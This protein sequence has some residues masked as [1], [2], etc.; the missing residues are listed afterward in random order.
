[1]FKLSRF[2]KSSS[3]NVAMLFG[4]ALVPLMA[5]AG[6][7]IDMIR[8]SETRTILQNAADSAA[9]AGAS[10][11]NKSDDALALKVREFLTANNAREVMEYV[12]DVDQVLD[13][14]AGT[15]TVTVSGTIPGSV[16]SLF[17][18]KDLNVNA[19]SVANVGSGSLELAL[20][21]DNTGSMSGTKILNL[22][23]AAT[24]L[25]NII[26]AESSDNA[27]VKMAVVPFA[28]YVNVGMGNSGQ[29]WV[30][31]STTGGGP[32]EGC[33]G[34][35]PAPY[36]LNISA[37]GGD[38]PALSGVACN[39]PILPLTSNLDTV[40]AAI[41]AMNAEGW[42]YISGGLLWG[43]NVLDSA[44]PFTEGKSKAATATVRGQ[45]V[46][47]LMTDGENTRSYNYPNHSGTDV[48]LAN[49]ALEDTCVAAK[50]D[51]I[52][53]YTVSFMVLTPTV[54]NLLE[55]C[56]TTPSQYYDADNSAELTAAFKQIAQELAAVR[57][58]Q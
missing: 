2:L 49:T 41:G 42:T 14:G 20:V 32:W 11:Q 35:R 29:S 24:D 43:W 44:A 25:V 3:G 12:T 17:G 27:D 39:S 40:K 16:M 45:K 31:M 5:G 47:V 23:S 19:K 4:M 48:G 26:Q 34:S 13:S 15:F 36:N 58:T 54:K 33:V 7:A 57:L 56:A 37:T 6:I 51:G 53:I 55:A 9:I 30:D 1:M 10:S 8:I 28:E 38:Y 21:L 50:A 52:A 18:F 22:K 46:V